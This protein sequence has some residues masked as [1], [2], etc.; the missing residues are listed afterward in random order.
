[1]KY[2]RLTT[3]LLAFAFAAV[4]NTR[5]RNT[6]LPTKFQVFAGI[7]TCTTKVLLSPAPSATCVSGRVTPQALPLLLNRIVSLTRPVFVRLTA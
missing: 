3:I 6:R 1:M 2:L 7:V 5:S 4:V